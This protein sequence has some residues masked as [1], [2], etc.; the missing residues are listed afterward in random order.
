[1]AV[2]AERV[3]RA[4]PRYIHQRD[5]NWCWA[6]LEAWTRIDSRCW[7]S[8]KRQDEWIADTGLQPYLHS[9]TKA[10]NISARHSLPRNP[11][12]PALLG[13]EYRPLQLGR[14]SVERSARLPAPIPCLCSL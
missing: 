5:L 7:S 12:P 13:M 9:T 2:T 10:L 11:L 1:M 8:V 3:D 14:A 4:R 6:A